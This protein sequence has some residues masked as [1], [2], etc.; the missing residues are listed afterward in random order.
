M[1]RTYVIRAVHPL[2]MLYEPFTL[3]LVSARSASNCTAAAAAQPHGAHRLDPLLVPLPMPLLMPL[4]VPLTAHLCA[5]AQEVVPP[6]ILRL[7]REGASN[8]SRAPPGPRAGAR[9]RR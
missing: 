8:V 2:R 4:L 6:S 5:D 7:A 9:P 1:S 3:L